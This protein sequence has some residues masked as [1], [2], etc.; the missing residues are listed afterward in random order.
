[1]K[2]LSCILLILLPGFLFAQQ[3]FTP[4]TVYQFESK[5]TTNPQ[6]VI[7]FSVVYNTQGNA[8]ITKSTHNATESD[9]EK[10][11]SFG[12]RSEL[13]ISYVQGDVGI[14]NYTYS[15]TNKYWVISFEN[16]TSKAL[17]GNTITITCLCIAGEGSCDVATMS[18]NTGTCSTCIPGAGCMQ[19]KME[20]TESGITSTG[21][22]FIIKANNI[23]LE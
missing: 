17:A 21:G 14:V 15:T 7:M 8:T 3:W 4:G 12:P 1:M 19:C 9:K 23:S 20:I 18:D 2:T 11:C 16:Y 6:Q 22:I 5:S 10:S 13:T